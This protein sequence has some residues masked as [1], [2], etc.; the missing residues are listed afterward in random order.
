MTKNTKKQSR[1]YSIGVF[2]NV[3][4]KLNLDDYEVGGHFA[5]VFSRKKLPWELCVFEIIQQIFGNY[6]I[7]LIMTNNLSIG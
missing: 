2:F 1:H 3:Y 7:H 4:K 5:D 6:N